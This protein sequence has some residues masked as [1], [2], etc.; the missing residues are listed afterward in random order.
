MLTVQD[1]LGKTA[2]DETSAVVSRGGVEVTGY[3]GF[4]IT[5]YLKNIGED[6]YYVPS[7]IEVDGGTLFNNV[8]TATLAVLHADETVNV[9]SKFLFGFGKTRITLRAGE[10]SFCTDGFIIGPFIF[11][12][13]IK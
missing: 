6:K 11:P 7:S 2:T 12:I 4:G 3:G 10:Y 8:T 1:S 5:M 9:K 13:K